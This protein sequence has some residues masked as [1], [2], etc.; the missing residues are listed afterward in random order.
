M[1]VW[2]SSPDKRLK[3]IRFRSV[4]VKYQPIQEIKLHNN[5]KIINKTGCVTSINNIIKKVPKKKKK[6]KEKC[7]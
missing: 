3:T 4:H 2:L 7:S 1:D 5:H 6:Q